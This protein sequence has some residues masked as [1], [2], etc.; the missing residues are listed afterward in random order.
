MPLT[1]NHATDIFKRTPPRLRKYLL[2]EN[3]HQPRVVLASVLTGSFLSTLQVFDEGPYVLAEVNGREVRTL[4][5]FHEAMKTPVVRNGRE[6]VVLLTEDE[7]KVVMP[8]NVL[9]REEGKLKRVH[10]YGGRAAGVV[11]PGSLF[12]HAHNGSIEAGGFV[13]RS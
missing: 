8:L 2:D 1:V 5:D 11:P 13:E 6:W 10:Q 12:S 7:V 4:A 3:C 9:R